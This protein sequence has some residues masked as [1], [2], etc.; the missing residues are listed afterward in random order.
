[1][2]TW[3]QRGEAKY[4]ELINYSN[5]ALVDLYANFPHP[6][7]NYDI[8]KHSLDG[9]D[10]G[11]FKTQQWE[12][13]KK[14]AQGRYVREMGYALE[15]LNIARGPKIEL[16]INSY[17]DFFKSDV[18]EKIK[19]YMKSKNEYTPTNNGIELAK[20]E[21]A[22]EKWILKMQELLLSY[23]YFCRYLDVISSVQLEKGKV[24][25][26]DISH[27]IGPKEFVIK[28]GGPE[29]IQNTFKAWGYYLDIFDILTKTG[30]SLSGDTLLKS[31]Q[32]KNWHLG[33]TKKYDRLSAAKKNL[34]F[35]IKKNPSETVRVPQFFRLAIINAW[36]DLQKRKHIVYPF[37]Y[38]NAVN[39]ALV[40]T[41]LLK[42]FN[43]NYKKAISINEIT[44]L[45]E[46]SLF[47]VKEKEI[48]D[49]IRYIESAGIKLYKQ[50]E[51]NNII[52]TS[53][54]KSNMNDFAY[55]LPKGEFFTCLL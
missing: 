1:M 31:N 23:G 43:N 10:L 36:M 7:K 21:Y 28:G 16:T 32:L 9:L 3:L 50:A 37:N 4:L 55:Y 53:L 18:K 19:N 14:K 24:T 8:V 41:V 44:K 33:W 30:K 22:S 20:L 34:T 6:I 42:I 26:E 12:W 45:I 47:K 25:L 46:D 52:F 13:L 27:V 2:T 38:K 29:F 48:L 17:N 11:A 40:R 15:C 49:D 39:R 5:W 51:K 35:K 54:R